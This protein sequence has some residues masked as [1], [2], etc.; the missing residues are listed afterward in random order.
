MESPNVLAYLFPIADP[1]DVHSYQ[2]ALHTVKRSENSLRYVPEQRKV[3]IELQTH[4]RESTVSLDDHIEDSTPNY[5]FKPGL[6]LTFNPGPRAG[7]GYFLGTDENS[8]DIVLP[9]LA[10]ISRRH[11]FFTFDEKRRLILQDCSQNGTIVTY[12]GKGGEKRRHFKWILSGD[13]VP[14]GTENFLLEF[15]NHLKFR[16]VVP[17]HET[18]PDLYAGRVDRFLQE[19]TANIDLPIDRLGI[20]SAST[21]ANQSGE[22]TPGRD[23]IYIPQGTLGKGAF[24]VVSRVWDVSTGKLYA[25]KKFRNIIGLDWRKEASIMEQISHVSQGY[26]LVLV[27]HFILTPLQEHIIEFIR[28]VKTPSPGLILEC[29]PFGNLGNQEQISEYE[30]VTILCQSLSALTYLHRKGI[31]HRDIKPENILVQSR[32]PLHIKLADFGLSKAAG[33]PRTVCGTETYAAPEVFEGDY[34]NACDIWS[35]GVIIFEYVYGLPKRKGDRGRRW[36]Q[37]ILQALDDWEDGLTEILSTA[38]LIMNPKERLPADECYVKAVWL[39]TQPHSLVASSHPSSQTSGDI[40]SKSNACLR[41]SNASTFIEPQNTI[42]RTMQPGTQSQ[43]LTKILSPLWVDLL[44]GRHAEGN[45]QEA[46]APSKRSLNGDANEES[47]QL[48]RTAKRPAIRIYSDELNQKNYKFRCRLINGQIVRMQLRDRKI[49]FTSYAQAMRRGPLWIR[50]HLGRID[51]GKKEEYTSRGFKGTLVDFEIMK[52]YVQSWGIQ[53]SLDWRCL[54]G[55][56]HDRQPLLEQQGILYLPIFMDDVMIPFN[57]LSQTVNITSIFTAVTGSRSQLGTLLKK[58]GI[59]YTS[60]HGGRLVQGTYIAQTDV[61][62]FGEHIGVDLR[63]LVRQAETWK[64]TTSA[65]D[66]NI[67]HEGDP[68]SQEAEIWK[69]TTSASAHISHEGDCLSEEA[70]TWK[71]TTSASAHISHEGDCLSEEAETWKST[72]SASA[73]IS[74]EGDSPSQEAETWKSAASAS[75][76]ISHEGARLSQLSQEI[77][78]D[79]SSSCNGITYPSDLDLWNLLS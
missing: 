28:V 5:L 17:K 51:C 65:S 2:Y 56:R 54:I 22:L 19:V 18:C 45:V 61:C 39:M 63:G 78:D 59:Q 29:A 7:P 69:S 42:L 1:E 36:C 14:E 53:D 77:G 13:R 38:M 43:H 75:A 79:I 48:Q 32:N 40:K 4:S 11:C 55:D 49:C 52:S 34:T 64:S 76:D 46:G 73:H 26:P 12:N 15:H 58:V 33:T 10:R 50:E 71:S 16:I 9:K 60:V 23:P 67:R 27:W 70:E 6:Q 31:V 68:L 35:L 47:L 72:T 74:H 66:S 24:S 30:V 62:K 57:T 37:R 20:Q 21:T 25:L 3:N 44:A 8:C 41:N